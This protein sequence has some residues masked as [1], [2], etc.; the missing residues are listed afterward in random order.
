MMAGFCGT[1]KTRAHN[2]RHVL[3]CCWHQDII[4]YMKNIFFLKL[5]IGIIAI[6]GVLIGGFVFWKP[7]TVQYYKCL[8]PVYAANRKCWSD[9]QA[10]FL[11][12]LICLEQ[13]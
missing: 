1:E 11:A 6:F 13:L 12:M 3:T 4:E 2:R 7:L 5:G 9:S 8:A 10:S